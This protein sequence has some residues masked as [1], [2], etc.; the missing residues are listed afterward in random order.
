[1]LRLDK[2]TMLTAEFIL[3]LIRE[4]NQ[5]EGNKARKLKNYYKGKQDIIKRTMIDT[6]KPNNKIVN[7]FGN[8]ITDM[9]VG[10]FMGS[11][12]SYSSLDEGA[13]DELNM[14]FNFNDE[15]DENSELAK[16]ASIAG[17]AY[18]LLYIDEEAK[19]RF[20][21]VSAEE[22][23]LIYD[24]SL[25]DN[26][27]YAIRYYSYY[28]PVKDLK[29]YKVDVYDKDKVVHYKCDELFSTL[30]FTSEEPHP[31]KDVP[32]VEYKN[33]EEI[34][35]DFEPVKSLI[36]A[37]DKMESE[38]LN[39]YEY[40]CDAYLALVNMMGTEAED[41]MAMKENRVMLLPEDSD[42]KFITKQTDVNAIEALKNRLVE[43]IHKFSKCPAMTDKEFAS[44]ASGVAMKFKV[45]GMENLTAI[46]ER[47][48]KKGL[49]R[50]IEL[51]F[52]ILDLYGSK[53]DWRAID[54]TFTRNLPTNDLEIADL[55]NKLRGLVSNETL[56]NQLP[57]I[58]DVAGEIEKKEQEKEDSLNMMGGFY[59]EAQG[60]LGKENEGA[61]KEGKQDIRGN[62]KDI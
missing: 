21:A 1:M 27:L 35:G 54:I 56:L 17:N 7:P 23:V 31:F 19:V 37:Y 53:Y 14:I 30:D 60:V 11:P 20:K 59:D 3:K 51:I 48:F 10:Y 45:M 44:N 62:E 41:V 49:Q 47:K 15:Q 42:A 52:N 2:D 26:I 18:E 4:H 55:V 29:G 6:S 61:G 33:N 28:N 50:R 38:G 34:I 12:V 36:D 8:Y 39:D 13:L 16:G 58:E 9:L 5:N 22:V 40:F 32:V 57:F 46:K 24:D 43:D 25:D